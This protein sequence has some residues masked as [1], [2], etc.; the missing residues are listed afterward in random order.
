MKKK[1]VKPDLVVEQF[2]LA[3]HIAA[4][5]YQMNHTG[6]ETCHI[7]GGEF[8]LPQALFYDSVNSACEADISK[9]EGVVCYTTG[10]DGQNIFS[11]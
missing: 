8:G 2:L 6:G 10:S 3:Q 9:Y 7:E 1:Y 11:S 4:C 5:D